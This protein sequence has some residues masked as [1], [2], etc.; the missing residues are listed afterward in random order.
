M[1]L[2]LVG[3]IRRRRFIFSGTAAIGCL[4]ERA[5]RIKR[6]Q[7]TGYAASTTANLVKLMKVLNQPQSSSAPLTK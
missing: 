6:P 2:P 3:R 5:A 4:V 7:L 1:L